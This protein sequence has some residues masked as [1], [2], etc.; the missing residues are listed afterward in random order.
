MLRKEKMNTEDRIQNVSLRSLPVNSTT[1]K[2]RNLSRPG[3]TIRNCTRLSMI[4]LVL[5]MGCGYQMVGKETHVPPGLSSIAIPTF[6][7]RTFEPGIE[8]PFTQAFLNEFIQ[9]KRVKVVSRAEADAILEGVV[10]SFIA[11]A[12]AYDRSGFVLQYTTSIVVDLSLRDRTGK[13][14]WQEG[15]SETQW[16]RASST[17]VTNEAAK[18]VA[19]QRTA[20][21]MAERIRNRFFYNF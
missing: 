13:V 7:N 15:A 1:E 2:F 21:F 6:K 9:D 16:F 8:I 17:G 20:G 12:G 11:A 5:L 3:G 18:Q 14:L 4:C 10:T 19:I